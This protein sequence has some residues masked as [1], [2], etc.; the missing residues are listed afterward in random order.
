MRYMQ[1]LLILGEMMRAI[2]AGLFSLVLV[3]QAMA[4]FVI[5][6]PN[7]TIARAILYDRALRGFS[8]A[9]ENVREVYSGRAAFSAELVVARETFWA[10]LNEPE[11]YEDRYSEYMQLLLAKDWAYLTATLSYGPG[12]D[13]ALV[14]SQ[15][16]GDIDGGLP[17][18]ASAAFERWVSEIRLFHGVKQG[19]F[20]WVLS[21][22][23][24]RN[25]LDSPGAV[26]AYNAYR[27]IRDRAEFAAAGYGSYF[28]DM[29]R[30]SLAAE[31]SRTPV[32]YILYDWRQD[33][34]GESFR[35]N[36]LSYLYTSAPEDFVPEINDKFL[37]EGIMLIE[38]KMGVRPGQEMGVKQTPN[39]LTVVNIG[40]M[41]G[42]LSF[43][44]DYR[45]SGVER[46]RI[47]SLKE[48][49]RVKEI[50]R[51]LWKQFGWKSGELSGND[52][53]ILTCIYGNFQKQIVGWY[54]QKPEIAPG[55]YPAEIGKMLS[56]PVLEACEP[57]SDL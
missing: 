11:G 45:T 31:S 44:D 42:I 28:D 14:L 9:M 15:F 21:G 38:H 13:E 49:D 41:R 56:A 55:P 19:E 46:A 54:K 48:T 3:S 33:K 40:V 6:P 1:H 10:K 50:E 8:Q 25:A 20:L 36:R 34:R 2:L 37:A 4:D 23:E 26:K 39:A 35:M 5:I 47:R 32:E 52:P 53:L 30:D 51:Y 57:F 27:M 17:S 7:R 12:S 16:G 29:I 24:L 43:W 18:E 22:Q